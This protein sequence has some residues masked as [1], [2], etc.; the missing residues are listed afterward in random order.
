MDAKLD[1]KTLLQALGL[2]DARLRQQESYGEICIFGGATM[3]LAFD[4][5]FATR[6]VDAIFVPKEKVTKAIEE[7][8]EELE[9][10]VDW[11]NDGVKGFVSAKGDLTKD[12]MPQFQNLRVL[13]PTA[14]YLLAMKCLASRVASYGS[15]G[16]SRDIWTLCQHLKLTKAEEVVK[17]ISDYYPESQIPAKARYLVEEILQEGANGEL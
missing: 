13:R 7:I 6:D 8:A 15:R 1:R 9:L 12:D 10:P 11:L 16:D 4:G 3:I 17:L 2:L 14:S 5:Q